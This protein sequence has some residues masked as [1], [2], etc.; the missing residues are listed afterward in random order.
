MTETSFVSASISVYS[1]DAAQQQPDSNQH[2]YSLKQQDE[3]LKINGRDCTMKG[4][5]TSISVHTA[6]AYLSNT[7]PSN[8]ADLFK[9]CVLQY[10]LSKQ[11][12][13]VARFV[14]TESIILHKNDLLSNARN[15]AVVNAKKNMTHGAL[16]IVRKEQVDLLKRMTQFIV[17]HMEAI[18]FDDP[19]LSSKHFYDLVHEQI[20]ND[21]ESWKILPLVCDADGLRY[22]CQVQTEQNQMSTITKEIQT[23]TILLTPY[24]YLPYQTMS[25]INIDLDDVDKDKEKELSFV[26]TMTERTIPTNEVSSPNFFQVLSSKGCLPPNRICEA[27]M[28]DIRGGSCA[29]CHK[30][31]GCFCDFLCNAGTDV[32]VDNKVVKKHVEYKV[33]KFK[34]TTRNFV[35]GQHSNSQV[36]KM[37]PNIVH[38][39]WFEAITKE[40]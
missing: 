13:T 8:A 11:N 6:F 9:F 18:E 28:K 2:H 31:C 5:D 12:V 10:E 7:S 3:F 15:T 19:F 32:D 30:F 26:T 33:P 39:T 29:K 23:R 24:H 16:L 20:A 40:K 17:D 38:Q 34:R 1:D 21:P 4:V 22:G 27:C 25:E 35:K 37:I 14:N 36:G